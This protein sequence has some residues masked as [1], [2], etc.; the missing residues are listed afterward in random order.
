MLSLDTADVTAVESDPI[1]LE[2]VEARILA[3]ARVEFELRIVRGRLTNAPA[4]ARLYPD[5]TAAERRLEARLKA[6]RLACPL[7]TDLY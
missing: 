2:R 4:Y 1:R 3:I 6:V 5:L 7:T